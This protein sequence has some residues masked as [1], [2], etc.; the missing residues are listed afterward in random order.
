[1][2]CGVSPIESLS[3]FRRLADIQST[4]VVRCE[5]LEDRQC[6]G[7]I[8]V[9]FSVRT[10]VTVITVFMLDAVLVS[11]TGTVEYRVAQTSPLE[12]S[13]RWNYCS[14]E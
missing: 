11:T 5:D 6:L 14:A 10:T 9:R 8:V 3:Y 4:L 13:Q 12:V 2:V 1:M 7:T